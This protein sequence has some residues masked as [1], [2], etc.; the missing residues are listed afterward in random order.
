MLEKLLPP[1]SQL[2]SPGVKTT[3]DALNRS[4][5]GLPPAVY[6][7]VSPKPIESVPRIGVAFAGPAVIAK[8][9]A[10]TIALVVKRRCNTANLLYALRADPNHPGVA[11]CDNSAVAADTDTPGD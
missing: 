8:A 7:I 3:V 5:V 10:T 11:R 2:I 9:A 1:W 4:V 6:G